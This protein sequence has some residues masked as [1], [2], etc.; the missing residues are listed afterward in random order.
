MYRMEKIVPLIGPTV[1]GPLGVKMLPRTWL[2][3]VLSAAGLLPEGYFDNDKGFNHRVVDALGLEP[4]AFFAFLATQPTYPQT[5]DYVR[6]HASKLDP[7]TIAALNDGIASYER[8]EE[9][10]AAVRALTGI[11]D[12]TLRN[13]ARLLDIDDWYA[14]HKAVL[15]HRADGIAPMIPMVS[16]AQV[17]L[18]GIP[19]LPRLWMKALLNAVHALHPEWKS[20]LVCGFDKRL[21][22]TIGLDLSAAVAYIN[23]ELPS[24]LQ[25]ERWVLAHI[26]PPD[27]ATKANWVEQFDGLKKGEE[28]ATAECIEA[29]APGAGVRGT[30]L[31]NDMVDWKFMHDQVAAQRVA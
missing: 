19:H 2:K 18:A 31:L 16:S 3:S 8:P 14:M 17:G 7:A 13:S 29:G 23:G 15:A 5:E 30:M 10:A 6:A 22:E 1:E 12:L 26:T 9:G 27:A 21:A 4:E 28:Q 20:G 25:F 11:E 24:Y